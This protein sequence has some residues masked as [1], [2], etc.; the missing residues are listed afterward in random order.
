MRTVT[1]SPVVDAASTRGDQASVETLFSGRLVSIARFRCPPGDH[2]WQHENWIGDRPHVVFPHVPVEIRQHGGPSRVA[3]PTQVVLYRAGEVYDRERLSPDGDRATFLTIEPDVEDALG[4]TVAST[5]VTVEAGDVLRIRMLAA[6]CLG[7]GV[8]PLA[9]EEQSLALVARILRRV[10]E[11]VRGWDCGV[12]VSFPIRRPRRASTARAH[13]QAV[14]DAQ[15]YLAVHARRSD[16]LA[17]IGSAIGV[18]PFHLARLFRARTGLSLHA[19]RDR[20]RVNSALDR[21]VEGDKDLAALAVELGFVSH[22]HFDLRFK[23]AFGWSPS[24]VRSLL[25]PGDRETSTIMEALRAT[26]S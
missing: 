13:D 6:L 14:V 1:A 20:L 4:A 16:S 11:T 12:A 21:L 15:R 5:Q 3:D 25:R 18:S 26:S 7:E 22:S 24:E 9:V 17:Q 23:R 19:Y 8:D 2:R 10:P